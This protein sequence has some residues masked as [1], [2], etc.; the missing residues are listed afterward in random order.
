MAEKSGKTVQSGSEPSAEDVR[1]LV[2][3]EAE[4]WLTLAA[5]ANEDTLALVARLRRELSANRARLVLEQAILRRRA[6]E[7]FT[8]AGKMFFTPTGLEQATDEVVAEYKASRFPAGVRVADLCCGIG[9]DL[10]ALALAGPTTGVDH[11]E[12]TAQFA[13]A[14]LRL[15]EAES[16]S[17]QCRSAE[18]FSLEGFT[19]WHIDPDRRPRGK[20]TTHVEFH[21]PGPSTIARLLQ[22]CPNAAMKLAPATEIVAEEAGTIPWHD[23]E[24]EWITHRRQCRQL[25]AWFG[26][27]AQA[28]GKR[29]AT[30]VAA[31]RTTGPAGQP[32]FLCL[33][34]F[35]GEDDLEL[36][37]GP[38][39][40]RYVYEPDPSML[41]AHLTGALAR[42]HHL[43]AVDRGVAYL[44]GDRLID[45]GL[46][47]A[48]EVIDVLPYDKKRL[49]AWLRE[50]KMGRLEIKKRGIELDPEQ[51]R[52]QL[53]VPGEEQAA[54][55]LCRI[56]GKTT[57]ILARRVHG[58]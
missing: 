2:G 1:W 55:L 28:P 15:V 10:T 12:T 19:A 7:K 21:A 44:T 49:K 40:S 41:A 38:R 20:R 22:E 26:D 27:L 17:V 23:A 52:R 6:T 58:E 31:G 14:N 30:L 24:L 33:A 32:S 42:E 37:V 9:G 43:A 11:D 50:R 8:F 25:V 29:R 13:A 36:S 56:A 51:I 57:A 47:S 53:S 18:G 35:V 4:R 34:T 54:I 5:T 46:L 16:S 48:F 45:T 3:P 39:I